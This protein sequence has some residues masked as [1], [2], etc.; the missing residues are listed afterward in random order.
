MGYDVRRSVRSQ[1][2]VGRQLCVESDGN[3]RVESAAT[4]AWNTHMR[5]PHLPMWTSG[6]ICTETYG[7]EITLSPAKGYLVTNTGVRIT[8]VFLMPRSEGHFGSKIDQKTHSGNQNQV[9][10]PTESFLARR[11]RRF[12]YRCARWSMVQ[13]SWQKRKRP[14]CLP[15]L[16]ATPQSGNC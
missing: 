5:R 2:G 9:H 10:G 8:L 13:S 1:P 3:F 6:R 7:L 4:F 16:R 11:N 14:A 15:G 12:L